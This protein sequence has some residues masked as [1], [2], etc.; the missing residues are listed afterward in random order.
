[1]K[2]KTFFKAKFPTPLLSTPHFHDIFGGSS[3]CDLAVNEKG[4]LLSV[5]TVALPGTKFEAIQ[6]CST[7]IY[8]VRTKDYKTK[9]QLFLDVRFVETALEK[10][11]ERIP[12]LP[13]P[14]QILKKM[15]SLEGLPYVWGGN[16]SEGIPQMLSF[17][18]P[19]KPLDKKKETIWSFSG[20]DC[21]GLLY[22]SSNGFTPRNTS[23]LVSYGIEISSHK[24]SNREIAEKIKPLDILVWKG[25]VIIAISSQET[26]ESKE[27]KGVIFS[28]LEDSLEVARKKGGEFFIRRWHPDYFQSA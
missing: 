5:E 2:G 27:G 12:H 3:G 4:F 21:S 9:C 8:E 24:E 14:E 25:H 13:K 1:M 23:E 16:Y 11:P 28:S 18:P 19:T 10:E 6:P 15:S 7:Y 17:Y 22:E 26:I 20:V